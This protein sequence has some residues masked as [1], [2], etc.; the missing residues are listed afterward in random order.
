LSAMI[1]R[2]F[3]KLF[4]KT[5]CPCLSPFGIQP[6]IEYDAAP[7]AAGRSLMNISRIVSIPYEYFSRG[8]PPL[9]GTQ[10]TETTSRSAQFS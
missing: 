3:F 5:S 2:D 4:E 10:C 9:F 8:N 6:S 1:S 7:R